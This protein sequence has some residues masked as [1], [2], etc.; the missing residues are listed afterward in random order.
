MKFGKKV[1][2][3]ALCAVLSLLFVLSGCN[4]PMFD[5]GGYEYPD[6]PYADSDPDIDSWTQWEEGD[7][8][9]I[10]WF[11][12]STSYSSRRKALSSWKKFCA[13]RALRSISVKLRPA[14]DPSLRRSLRG[15][16][17]PT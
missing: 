17:F 6:F 4:N 8:I 16:I 2:C 14:T 1:F 3:A 7:I 9:E 11:I 12:D 15:T 13:R 5:F 10:D